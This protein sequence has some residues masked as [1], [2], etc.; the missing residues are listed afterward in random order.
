[1]DMQEMKQR[2]LIAASLALGCMLVLG[3]C[4]KSDGSREAYLVRIRDDIRTVS[5]FWQQF[6]IFKTAYPR[7]SLQSPEILQEARM[8]LLNQMVEDLVLTQRARELNIQ[9]ADSELEAAF[10]SICEDY[11]PGYFKSIALEHAVPLQAWKAR[12][13]MQLL[14]EKLV[15]K[16]LAG[17]VN[18][19]VEEVEK[20]YQEH[21]KEKDFRSNVR[22][23]PQQM[24]TAVVENLRRLKLEAAYSPWISSL[25]KKYPVEVNRKAWSRLANQ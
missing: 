16:E 15:E 17:Q 5:D 24:E 23:D 14:R 1:M 6:E 9:V 25:R 11:P 18:I 10:L 22:P 13:K 4:F 8:R 3:G 21:Y 12:L 7:S 19:T 20:Y 2:L